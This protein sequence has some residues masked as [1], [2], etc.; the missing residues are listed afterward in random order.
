MR[1]SQMSLFKNSPTSY[2]GNLLKTRKGRS[3][4]RPLDTKNSMHLVLRSTKARASWSFLRGENRRAIRQV[5]KKFSAKFGV[6]ILSVANVGN[7][8]HLHIQLTSRH[9]YRPFIRAITSAIATQVTGI[10]RW[11]QNS[12]EKLCFWDLRPFSR[13]IK[14]WSGILTLSNY[15]KINQLEGMGIC[16]KRAESFIRSAIILHSTA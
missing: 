9:S 2:G 7:H 3:R 4:G 8:L 14:G 1:P 5:L 13:V 16:R 6:K 10:N 12:G 15:I 11:T